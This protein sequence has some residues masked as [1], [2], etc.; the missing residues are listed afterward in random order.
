MDK[1]AEVIQHLI[2]W[3]ID[4]YSDACKLILCCEDDSDLLEPVKSRCKVITLNAPLAHEVSYS[5]SVYGLEGSINCM[6]NYIDLFL[7][8]SDGS[9]INILN[10]SN[11]I[12]E[13]LI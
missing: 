5:V 7:C 8:M 11:F 4:C 2:K 12:M 3:I 9:F 1:A 6:C 13:K 10:L